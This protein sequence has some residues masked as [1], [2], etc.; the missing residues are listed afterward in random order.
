MI[1][2]ENKDLFTN[3]EVKLF[4]LKKIQDFKVNTKLTN[5]WKLIKNSNKFVFSSFKENYEI[6]LNDKEVIKLITNYNDYTI[7][8]KQYYFKQNF[9]IIN[10]EI[11]DENKYNLILNEI[12]EQNNILDIKD[13][14]F[15]VGNIYETQ[16]NSKF[17]YLGIFYIIEKTNKLD[18]NRV[19]IS[20]SKTKKKHLILRLDEYCSS[21]D[22]MK[23]NDKKIKKDLG[24]FDFINS[25]DIIKIYLEKY[26]LDSKIYKISKDKD[27]SPLIELKKEDNNFY[28]MIE[29]GKKIFYVKDS[30][31]DYY[32][33]LGK[34]NYSFEEYVSG[35]PKQNSN[36]E[37]H[38]FEKVLIKDNEYIETGY[39]KYEIVKS[40]AWYDF[41]NDLQ[42]TKYYKNKY[43][44][45]KAIKSS[46]NKNEIY[47]LD[48]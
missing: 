17:I 15:I 40:T 48:I 1:T 43:L 45:F 42:I 32:K 3:K 26:H 11:L 25:N 28:K 21:F 33:F 7:L 13:K 31:G 6:K 4:N 38:L 35:R 37:Y 23:S 44:H 20:I 19:I 2:I 46:I 29:L 10:N 30:S 8:N 47:T 22:F 18:K 34:K 16:N 39:F 14:D 9:G 41:S 24:T 36:I 27:V 5:D 12:K